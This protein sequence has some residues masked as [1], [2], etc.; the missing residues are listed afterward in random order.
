MKA[1]LVFID[2]TICDGRQRYQLVDTPEFYQRESLLADMVVPGSLE[3]LHELARRYELVYIGAQ[4]SPH[5]R[6]R[7][8]GCEKRGFHPGKSCWQKARTSGWRW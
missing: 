6:S 8:N 1:I 2:G 5:F 4:Q 7:K 3:A